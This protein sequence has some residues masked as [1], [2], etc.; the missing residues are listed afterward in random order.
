[1][2]QQLPIGVFDS[3]VG[4]LTVL[5]QLH[6]VLPDESF[7]Y[8]GDMA[9]LP[10]GTK[11]PETVI[12]YGIQ[13]TRLLLSKGIKALVIAC[14]TA[15]TL[16]LPTLRKEFPE[17]PILGVV[18]PGAEA[19]ARITEN[20]HIAVLATEA[21]IKA[22]GYE[23]A[24]AAVDPNI[25][26]TGKSCGLFVAIAEEGWSE[27]DVAR[28]TA[29]QYLQPI[30]Q[31]AHHPDTILL[32]CTHFPLLE[33][34]IAETVGPHVHII[35]SAHATADVFRALLMDN[36]LQRHQASSRQADRYLVTD[37]PERFHRIAMR[38][39]PNAVAQESIELVDGHSLQ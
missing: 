29:Q 27:T 34:V 23:R 20:K 4:G 14:N 16:A 35:D 17:L 38:F 9:R 10:Y 8:L 28:L 22:A 33:Q 11:S 37:S 36:K 26:V 18:E 31:Q 5:K 7:L 1:M 25:S 13:A 6:R 2:T 30:F 12:R 3:G 15:S 19:A 32:G 24:I 21:T 39:L